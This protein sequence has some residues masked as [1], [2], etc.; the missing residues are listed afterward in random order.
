MT[1][2]VDSSDGGAVPRIV[3]DFIATE[4]ERSELKKIHPKACK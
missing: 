4:K 1:S 3:Y 2:E